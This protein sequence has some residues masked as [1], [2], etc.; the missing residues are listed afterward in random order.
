M[1]NKEL[2]SKVLAFCSFIPVAV[3]SAVKFRQRKEWFALNK[4][5]TEH[6]PKIPAFHV[7]LKPAFLSWSCCPIGEEQKH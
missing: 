5:R 4:L 1:R 3:M 6:G 7:L 2:N